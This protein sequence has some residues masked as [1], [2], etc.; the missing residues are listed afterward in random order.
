MERQEVTISASNEE[1]QWKT[2]SNPRNITAESESKIVFMNYK[3]KTRQ[4]NQT[5]VVGWSNMSSCVLN[6][7]F[8]ASASFNITVRVSEI[9]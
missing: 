3:A 7:R 2:A 9:N 6:C 5:Y 1:I 8:K 4:H